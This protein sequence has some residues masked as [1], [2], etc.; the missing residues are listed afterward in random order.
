MPLDIGKLDRR[1]T[2]EQRT[3]TRDDFGEPIPAWSTLATVWAGKV[4]EE[5]SERFEGEQ[6]HATRRVVW[7][8]RHR[9]D[10]TE[11]MRILFD[12]DHYDIT[13]I[14]EIGRKEGLQIETL[15]EVP[16]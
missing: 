3:D 15:L 6:R 9:T 11:A 10:V 2:I 5:G 8:I 12:G 1:V 16:Q 7:R 14:T 13:A 4:S